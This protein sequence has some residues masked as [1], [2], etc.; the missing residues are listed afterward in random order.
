MAS[1]LEAQH[2][3][4]RIR[5]QAWKEENAL[6]EGLG[7]APLIACSFYPFRSSFVFCHAARRYG[8][9]HSMDY[10]SA[11]DLAH[12]GAFKGGVLSFSSLEV[13]DAAQSVDP[14]QKFTLQLMEE[15][16]LP[17]K[18]R[19]LLSWK[20]LSWIALAGAVCSFPATFQKKWVEAIQ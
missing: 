10:A 9:I 19:L 6:E 8:Q 1:R 13:L 16:K 17:R 15:P 18:K 4:L 11:Q 5:E 20:F 3:A 2:F 14:L 7:E 12:F